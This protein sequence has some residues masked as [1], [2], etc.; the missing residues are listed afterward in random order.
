VWAYF[1]EDGEKNRGQTE[2]VRKELKR[3]P[4]QSGKTRGKRLEQR[5]RLQSER[6]Q[7]NFDAERN[8]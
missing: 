1:S 3:V 7:K 5:S 8:S 6:G 2:M 4:P